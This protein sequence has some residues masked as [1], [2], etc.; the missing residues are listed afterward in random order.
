MRQTSDLVLEARWLLSLA[1]R[2]GMVYS[3]RG[4]V[5][6]LLVTGTRSIMTKTGDGVKIYKPYRTCSSISLHN[7]HDA[8]SRLISPSSREEGGCSLG[9]LTS[10]GEGRAD[11]WITQVWTAQVHYNGYFFNSKFDGTVVGWMCGCR[12]Q[13]MWKLRYR[14]LS[15]TCTLIFNCRESWHPNRCAVQGSNC[16][17]THLQHFSPII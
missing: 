4:W 1:P 10:T 12:T 2:G 14:G 15:I 7:S 16:I 3:W 5:T 8:G 11:P 9:T 17:H 6:E 13:N